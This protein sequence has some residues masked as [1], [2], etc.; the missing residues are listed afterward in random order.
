MKDQP[1]TQPQQVFK[2][3]Q[4]SASV[5]FFI[6]FQDVETVGDD[7]FFSLLHDVKIANQAAEVLGFSPMQ[8][9]RKESQGK[10]LIEF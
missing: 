7:V 4:F 2:N 3:C 8:V 1:Q 5:P 6:Q 9:I 10:R